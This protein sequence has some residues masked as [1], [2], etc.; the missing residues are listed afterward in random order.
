MVYLE[1]N[2]AATTVATVFSFQTQL[3]E[4]NAERAADARHGVRTPRIPLMPAEDSAI[5]AVMVCLSVFT[6][7]MFSSC[8]VVRC[9]LFIDSFLYSTNNLRSSKMSA[10]FCES[11]TVNPMRHVLN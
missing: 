7:L 2:I 3:A 6:R 10:T 5:V 4:R 1:R 9:Y 11:S 8:F